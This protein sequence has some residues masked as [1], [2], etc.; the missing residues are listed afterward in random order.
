MEKDHLS[1]KKVVKNY[2]TNQRL[3]SW[4][5][6]PIAVSFCPAAAHIYR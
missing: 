4:T 3:K 1:V 2:E 6:V 5:S